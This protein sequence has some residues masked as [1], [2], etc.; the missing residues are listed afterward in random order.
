MQYRETGD[1]RHRKAGT[2]NVG[3]DLLLQNGRSGRGAM[4][5]QAAQVRDA[6]SA[7]PPCR[8]RACPPHPSGGSSSFSAPGAPFL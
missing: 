8:A 5:R 1:A 7:V 4:E 6:A 3:Q 2:R